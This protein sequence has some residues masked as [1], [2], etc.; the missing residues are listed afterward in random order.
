LAS[1]QVEYSLLNRTIEKNGVLDLCRDLGIRVIAH[2]P[3]GLGVLTGKYSPSNPPREMISRGLNRNT[4]REIQPLMNA[5]KRIGA[6]HDGKTPAQ[7]ALNWIIC[8]GVLPIPGAKNDL[9]ARQNCDSA[10]WRLAEGEVKELDE[11]S[12]RIRPTG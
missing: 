8:K 7:V 9:Q 5:M 3:L 10:G 4:L 1:N 2:C 12:D 6:S 11:L